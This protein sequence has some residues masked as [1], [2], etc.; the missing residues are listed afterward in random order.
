[1]RIFL[2]CELVDAGFLD[3]MSGSSFS[4][5]WVTTRLFFKLLLYTY[6]IHTIHVKWL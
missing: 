1:V 6:Q 2:E 4:A 3:G 5:A